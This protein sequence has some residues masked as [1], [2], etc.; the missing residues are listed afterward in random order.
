MPRN[1]IPWDRQPGEPPLW[2]KRFW[3]YC[4]LGVKRTQIAVYNAEVAAAAAN[5]GIDG[6]VRP[7]KA[8]DSIPRNWTTQVAKW[9]W[10]E[11]AELYDIEQVKADRER[12]ER[13]LR[14]TRKKHRD[15]GR[16]LQSIALKKL[17]TVTPDDLTPAVSS[18]MLQD[19]IRIELNA[20]EVP[21]SIV[22]QRRVEMG[23][24]D[25]TQQEL[26]DELANLR[27]R[28]GAATETAGDAGASGEAGGAAPV[29]EAAGPGWVQA[30]D[31]AGVGEPAAPGA[32]EPA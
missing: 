6:K 17:G 21:E 3:E 22:E 14:D 16:V 23:V 25:Y 30:D 15:Y 7:P 11:R 18:T 5:G 26:E 8:Y 9:R 1:H 29:D 13:D 12:H 4:K 10:V 32:D 27:A 31:A 2:Y 28:I 19:G 24:Q 20:L